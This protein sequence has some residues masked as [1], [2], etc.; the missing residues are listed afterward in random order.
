LI[1]RN[2]FN[3]AVNRLLH[4][5]T[6]VVPGARTVRPFLHR[7]RGVRIDGRVF[8]GDDVYIENEYPECVE[9]NDDAR[10]ALRSTIIAHMRGP[11]RVIIGQKVYVGPH[12]FI[13]ASS[14]QTIIIGEGSVL[15]AGCVVTKSVPPYTFVVGVPG[16][17]KARVT[18]PLTAGISPEDFRKGLK[19]LE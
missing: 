4:L 11:G 17:P 8:I 5:L 12:C 2:A 14:G 9:I 19:P 6:R 18:V 13:G 10:I 16:R 15:A 1:K 7:L 3:R